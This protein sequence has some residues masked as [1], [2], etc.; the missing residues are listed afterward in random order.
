M[1]VAWRQRVREV[2]FGFDGIWIYKY[3]ELHDG[4]QPSACPLLLCVHLKVPPHEFAPQTQR[5]ST[6]EVCLGTHEQQ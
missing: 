3:G 5:T 1:D 6:S 4:V 2:R